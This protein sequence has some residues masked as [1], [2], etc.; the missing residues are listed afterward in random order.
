MSAVDVL[1]SSERRHSERRRPASA[2]RIAI[3]RGTGSLID[4]SLGGLRTRHTGAVTRGSKVRVAFDWQHERFDAIAEVLASRVVSLGDPVGHGTTFESRLHFVHMPPSSH[5]LL[6][7]V[8]IAI[9]SHE[10]R[11]WVANLNG[12]NDEP[13]PESAATAEGSFIRCRLIGR[14]WQ[15]KWTHDPTQPANGFVLPASIGASELATLC[16]TYLHADPDGRHL[17]RLMADEAVRKVLPPQL[18]VAQ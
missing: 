7:R 14:Q 11:R 2:I 6:E 13:Q 1:T 18:A 12:W 4:I 3:G 15:R 17:I 16:E 8:F 9:T 5:E 10:L